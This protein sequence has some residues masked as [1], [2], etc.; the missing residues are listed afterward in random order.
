MPPPNIAAYGLKATSSH[1]AAEKVRK[2]WKKMNK[3][4]HFSLEIHSAFPFTP[5]LC[6]YLEIVRI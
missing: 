1:A 6:N 3:F 4:Y 5:D 2:D